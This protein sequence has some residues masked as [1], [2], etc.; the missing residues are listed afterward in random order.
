MRSLA[1]ASSTP[2]S[3]PAGAG[4]A[5]VGPPLPGELVHAL[6]GLVSEAMVS[7]GVANRSLGF[8]RG[9]SRN[10]LGIETR[11]HQTSKS[12]DL[13]SDSG[14]ASIEIKTDAFIRAPQG[15][16]YPIRSSAGPRMWPRGTAR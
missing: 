16:E 9:W 14:I 3:V 7:V 6:R 11:S 8:H 1:R 15:Q 2:S 4:S 5:A 12:F 13:C 10:R